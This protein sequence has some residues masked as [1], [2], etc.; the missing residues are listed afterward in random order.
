MPNAHDDGAAQANLQ[1]S[2]AVGVNFSRSP[3][4]IR[5]ASA[6]AAIV[7]PW[8]LDKLSK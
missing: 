5:H 1:S 3:T 2:K 7:Y 8:N 6:S 4:A